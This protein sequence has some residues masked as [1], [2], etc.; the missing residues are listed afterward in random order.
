MGLG[1]VRGKMIGVYSV[2]GWNAR[3]AGCYAS[4]SPFYFLSRCRVR[5]LDAYVVSRFE[6]LAVRR[7]VAIAPWVLLKHSASA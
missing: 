5:Y 6:S 4:D 3:S 7:G 1:E 2:G